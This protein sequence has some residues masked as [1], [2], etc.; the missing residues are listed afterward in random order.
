MELTNY[1]N[2]FVENIKKENNLDIFK[3]LKEDIK[4]DLLIGIIIWIAGSTVIGI[5]IV[6]GIIGYRGFCFGYTISS[7]IAVLGEKQ[8]SLISFIGI[9]LQNIIFIPSIILIASSGMNL[10]KTIIKD[11]KRE[12]IKLGIY[13]HSI[14]SIIGFIGIIASSI[15]EVYVSTNLLIFFAKYM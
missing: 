8:G 13:R 1:I 11:K 12:N 9:F 15:I 7:F 10:Y 5:P 3:I 6:Y 4:K 14:I 2:Q